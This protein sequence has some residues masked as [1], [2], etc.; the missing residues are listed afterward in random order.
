MRSW[1]LATC[2]CIGA[3]GDS[4]GNDGDG[5]NSGTGTTG[6]GNVEGKLIIEPTSSVKTSEPLGP[7][8]PMSSNLFVIVAVD[9]ENTTDSSLPLIYG[10][11]SVQDSSGVEFMG[12]PATESHPEGCASTSSLGP[13]GTTSCT[14]V[15]EVPADTVTAKIVYTTPD[16]SDRYEAPL[17]T[18]T[19]IP[20]LGG[21]ID[22]GETCM[23]SSCAELCA[24]AAGYLPSCSNTGCLSYCEARTQA[25]GCLELMGTFYECGFDNPANLSCEDFSDYGMVVSPFPGDCLPEFTEFQDQ[26]T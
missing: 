4:S 20:C 22:V 21:C 6:T 10:L 17:E 23:F 13:N 7:I 8:A 11:F 14:L 15:F 25:P 24:A 12:H 19:C 1:L 26:C 2:V 18:T 3:C 9:L 16:G 5:G